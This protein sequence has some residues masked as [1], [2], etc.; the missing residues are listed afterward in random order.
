MTARREKARG[1]HLR[2]HHAV[3][4]AVATWISSL[5]GCVIELSPRPGAPAAARGREVVVV[6]AGEEPT[7]AD[8]GPSKDA[9]AEDAAGDAIAD[10]P[11]VA[12]EGLTDR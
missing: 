7:A 6:D 8:A 11:A 9:G 1:W 5:V 10:A 2:G 12:P 4:V 3:F